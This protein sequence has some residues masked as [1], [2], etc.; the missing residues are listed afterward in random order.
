MDLYLLPAP[1]QAWSFLRR[2]QSYQNVWASCQ[3][4]EMAVSKELGFPILNQTSDDLMAAEWGLLAF[5]APNVVACE[6]MPF[7]SIWPTLDAD[8]VDVCDMPFIPMVRES[9]AQIS[10]LRLLGDELVLGIRRDLNFIQLRL[11]IIPE[12]DRW[13]IDLRLPFDLRLSVLL[14]RARDLWSVAAGERN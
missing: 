14:A 2:N 12:G 11:P 4:Q 3:R 7:W 5:E 10:G 1:L 9:G 13:G 8:I 6:A